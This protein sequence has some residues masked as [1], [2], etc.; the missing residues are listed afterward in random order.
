MSDSTSGTPASGTPGTPGGSGT[1]STAKDFAMGPADS[2]SVGQLAKLVTDWQKIQITSSEDLYKYGLLVRQIGLE[3]SMRMA[4]DADVIAA[5]LSQYKGKWYTFGV[6]SKIRGRLVSAHLKVG[7]E[8]M[9]LAGLSGPKM[10]AS[11]IKHFVKPEI[12]AR[13]KGKK[14]GKGAF[15]IK[16]AEETRGGKRA[17]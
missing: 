5:V 13:D 4:M 16:E 12:E 17:A 1:P 15:T 3:M 7:A 10:Y 14:N 8:A 11:F 9:R 2:S 6:Q